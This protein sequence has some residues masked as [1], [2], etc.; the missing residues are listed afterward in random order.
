MYG[1][2]GFEGWV[3][4]LAGTSALGWNRRGIIS[5]DI[6]HFPAFTAEPFTGKGIYRFERKVRED[7]GV[8]GV[9]V[10]RMGRDLGEGIREGG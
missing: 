10:V 8:T 6:T 7:F 1:W 2:G 3:D 5:F 9:E 4:E